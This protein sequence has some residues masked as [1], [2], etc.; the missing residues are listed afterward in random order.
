MIPLRQPGQTCDRFTREDRK[1]LRSRAE[2]LGI[3]GLSPEL[4][5]RVQDANRTL[6]M[7][8]GA[9]SSVSGSPR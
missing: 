2:P 6:E 1:P 4:Y 8:C 3:S 7:T 9:I 5:T